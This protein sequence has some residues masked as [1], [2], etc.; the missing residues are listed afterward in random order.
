MSSEGVEDDITT[1]KRNTDAAERRRKTLLDD[2]LVVLC[3]YDAL[4]GGFHPLSQTCL[5]CEKKSECILELQNRYDFDVLSLR[6]GTLTE[7][8]A[9]MIR[10]MN[11]RD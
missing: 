11:T 4:S 6:R 5:A 10:M 8:D 9:R 2:G 7:M 3:V 1:A